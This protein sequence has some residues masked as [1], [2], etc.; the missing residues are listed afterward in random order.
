MAETLPS[1]ND[2]CTPCSGTAT[3]QVPGPTGTTGS[4]GSDGT[5]GVNAHTTTTAD[6]DMPAEAATVVV[7]VSDSTWMT[8][9]QVLYLTTA[10]YMQVSAK[11]TTTSVTLLNLE[12]TANSLYTDNAAPTT[13]IVSGAS[14]SPAGIQGPAGVDSSGVSNTVDFV[15]VTDQTGSGLASSQFLDTKGTGVV[16][17]DDTSDIVSTQTVGVSD[18][19]IVEVDDAA[20]LTSGEII[21]A[22]ANGI[23]SVTPATGRTSLGLGTSAVVDT[24]VA[25]NQ[26]VTVDQAAGLTTGE[27]VYATANGLETRSSGSSSSVGYGLL[28]KVLGVDVNSVGDNSISVSAS[29]FILDKAVAVFASGDPSAGQM[30]IRNASGGGGVALF[31]NTTLTDATASGKYQGLTS[32]ASATGSDVYSVNTIYG[33][34]TFADN[35]TV[36]IYVYGW[37]LS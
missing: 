2:C 37:I 35:G 36:D 30:E 7:N 5:D 28:G 16:I 8:T 31:S 12:D 3:V 32:N 29:S 21:Q 6:F 4:S 22:T 1:V 18:D 17:F 14:V 19:N 24:G 13:V 25:D 20:G 11:P 33:R 34:V 26:V 23:E 9:N 15:T 10:G 27:A